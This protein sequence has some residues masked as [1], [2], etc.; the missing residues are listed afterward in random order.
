[1]V[2]E[3]VGVVSI[4]QPKDVC[5]TASFIRYIRRSNAIM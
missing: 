4:K 3:A 2:V 5:E 1:M